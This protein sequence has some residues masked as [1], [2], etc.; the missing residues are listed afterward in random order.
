MKGCLVLQRQF[1]YVGHELA[2]LLKEKHGIGEFCVFANQRGS[3]DFLVS[4]KDIEY[5]S[6]MLDEDIHKQYRTELLDLPYL[7][8]FEKEHGNLWSFINVDRVIRLGQL[9]RE[10]PYDTPP[11]T[12]EEMLRIVQVYAK[13]ISAFLDRERPDFVFTYLPGGLWMVLLNA[14]AK[15]RGIPVIFI[16]HPLT[17][18]RISL[19]LE[20]DRLTW[21]EK[22]VERNKNTALEAIPRYEQAR[23]HIEEF[24]SRPAMYSAAY[25]SLIHHGRRKYF[26]FLLPNN[27]LRSVRW[28]LKMVREWLRESERRD[29]YITVHPINYVVDRVRRKVRNL[30]GADD[31]YDAYDPS[32]PFVFYPL[33]YEPEL[34]VLLLA[35]FDT[36]QLSIV[37]RLARS[38][39]AG[40]YVYV[41]EHPQMVPFRPRAYYKELKKIPNV[42][43][44]RPELSSFD[45]I[46]ASKLVAIISGGAGWEA[47]LLGKPVITFGHIFYN[48][49][50]S[51]AHSS[52]PEELPELVLRQLTVEARLEDVTRFFVAL[53][54]ESAVCDLIYI[55]EF[56][57]DREKRRA[58][59]EE[60]AGFIAKKIRLVVEGED[61]P[62]R[63]VRS[64]L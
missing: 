29:D 59:L 54:E 6:I 64:A 36:D 61:A 37:R 27:L 40:M 51:V 47:T 21:V 24:R 17:R 52:V 39:P 22:A 4:Q 50:P 25:A 43:L 10:Y 63:R 33:H 48:A 41:K 32:K 57:T 31:L 7:E 19:S 42:R 26:K 16:V 34:T 1:A 5:T 3:Y 35:P 56:E 15:K 20:Y 8:A 9:V 55:W 60:F 23:R 62:Q 18:D 11:Y 49:L 12:Y 45:I 53:L 58:A 2:V 38:L 44:I 46:R 14:I 28:I 30:V 13:N